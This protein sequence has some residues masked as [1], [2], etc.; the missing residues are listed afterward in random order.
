MLSERGFDRS[1][2]NIEPFRPGQTVHDMGLI[3]SQT[4]PGVYVSASTSLLK[5][6][7]E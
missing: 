7:L 1:L 6:V 5:T 4:S 2:K 3:L